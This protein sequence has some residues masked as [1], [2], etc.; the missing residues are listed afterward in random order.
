MNPRK[1]Q[2]KKTGLFYAEDG[3]D[4]RSIHLSQTAKQN[5]QERRNSRI[6]HFCR[7]HNLIGLCDELKKQQLLDVEESSIIQ[8]PHSTEI[9]I[10]LYI[11]TKCLPTGRVRSRSTIMRI[12]KKKLLRHKTTVN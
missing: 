2:Y 1:G 4:K 12:M 7:Q 9:P 8:D 11:T 6:Y 3:Y 5:F 10:N